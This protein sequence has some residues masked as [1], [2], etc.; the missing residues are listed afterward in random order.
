M[1]MRNEKLKLSPEL[2]PW[3]RQ[4]G[5]STDDYLRFTV[6]LE[7]GEDRTLEQAVET[8]NTTNGE[9]K[10]A[11]L[12]LFKKISALNRW[13]DRVAAYNALQWQQEHRRQVKLWKDAR[14]RRRKQGVALQAKGA[15]VLAAMP[16]MAVSPHD[17]LRLIVEGARM[18]SDAIGVP[19]Q[20]RPAARAAHGDTQTLDTS[21]WSEQQ[22]RAYM[23]DM[24]AEMAARSGSGLFD[25]DDE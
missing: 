1:P 4:P 16:N 15:Q 18:E 12:S 11:S 7:L 23:R 2:A 5:E 21:E 20:D 17:A 22:I 3:A 14:E 24:A 19:E 8:W 10:Q 6:F 13:T 9:K 25:D